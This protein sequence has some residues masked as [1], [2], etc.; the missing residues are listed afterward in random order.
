MKKNPQRVVIR[1]RMKDL[2]RFIGHI[3]DRRRIFRRTSADRPREG[4]TATLARELHPEVQH[5]R[6]SKIRR[7]S[8]STLTFR[9]I[10]A[11]T[12]G[13]KKSIAPFQA[14][15]YLSVDVQMDSG[16][17]IS[18]PYSISNTPE[19]ARSDNAYEITVNSGPDAFIA[20]KLCESWDIGTAVDVS[21]PCGQFTYEPLRDPSHLV[22]LAGGSGITPFRSIIGDV[23]SREI[24]VSITL[25]QGA[26]NRDELIYDD[27]FH[28]LEETH[29]D[30]F[31]RISVLSDSPDVSEPKGSNAISVR[32]GFINSD[33]LTEAF[34][35]RD[36]AVF[37]CG[38]EAMHRY[39]NDEM[40]KAELR[41][42]RI[43]SEDYGI[44]GRPTGRD[45]VKMTVMTAGLIRNVP[46]DRDE[47][48]LVALERAG[49]EPP[50]RCRTGS[51]GWCRGALLEGK[52]RYDKNPEGLRSAD[53]KLGFF[54]PCAAKPETDLIIDIPGKKHGG[55][56][57][58]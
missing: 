43:R 37:I 8:D 29:P 24:G 11:D 31:K 58:Y 6:V 4:Y 28:T 39:I 22:C 48:V 53:R 23:L 5:L 18:R 17:F 7:E 30:R 33:I 52:I 27:E 15:Q 19:E 10:P 45:P 35:G 36:S 1:G 21:D 38:P 34:N 55:V 50:S 56:K 47:T 40:G 14:G 26:A 16:F 32:K 51:C 49:M 44:P 13:R 41:P 20:L 42:K 25:V 57:W 12:D 46:A 9:L 3:G 2:F 54:H